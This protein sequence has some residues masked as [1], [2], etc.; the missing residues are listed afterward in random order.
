MNTLL[1]VILLIVTG[2]ALLV[3]EL[4][5][6]PGFGL[7]GI[8][9]CLSIAGGVFCA[10]SYIGS[11]AGH[12]ALGAS[13]L[14]C[15]IGIYIFMRCKTLDKMAL[16][17]NIDSKVDL[18]NGTNIEVGNRGITISRL[19]PIGKVRIDKVEVEAKSYEAFIDQGILVEVVTLDGNKVIVK[20]LD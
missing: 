14:L 1:V 4:F 12:I 15:I 10:Y 8:S 7:A 11:T 18:I 5:L 17:K 16:R 3:I 19:A 13:V 6:I 20:P 2:V 9:G